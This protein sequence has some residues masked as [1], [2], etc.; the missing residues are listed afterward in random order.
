M[1]FSV[2]DLALLLTMLLFA[3]LLAL[4]FNV[5]WATPLAQRIARVRAGTQSV[6]Q[7]VLDTTLPVDG[8]DEIALLATDFNRM[9]QTLV[10]ARQHE[11]DLEQARRDLVAAVSHDLRTP[12]AASRAMLEALVDGVAD[13]PEIQIRYLVAVHH[14]ITHL[15]QLV[16]DLF[17]LAQLDAG[18]LQLTLE[19][20]SLHDL[21]SDTLA[22]FGPQAQQQGVQ[23]V[24]EVQG[25]I[26][27]VLIN[28][29]KLQ[30]VLHNLL[31][32]ALHHTPADGTI[33][34]R[35]AACGP[36]VEVEVS[37]TG[38]GIA[39]SDLP[40]V[41]DRSFRSER[42]RTRRGGDTAAGAGLG[43]AIA[44]GLV[45]AHGGTINVHSQLE[46]GASFRFTL[47]RVE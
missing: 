46:Q 30:R 16:D 27:P 18:A 36:L 24:G 25:E 45:E 39:P 44:R 23:L 21:L 14:E 4:G 29:P 9:A 15:S 22:A 47:R 33:M 20:A 42:S 26:D 6:A 34:L 32:N 35:A 37:D 2:H 1:F 11:H 28:P 43:L 40:H 17:E 38:E 7:G 41:F 31:I 3:A 13:E 19:R 8:N 10:Q 12:I 5:L